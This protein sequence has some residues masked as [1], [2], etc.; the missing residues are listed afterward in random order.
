MKKI[1]IIGAGPS[2]MMAALYA[3]K[4][5]SS[6]TLLDKNKILGKKLLITGGGRCNITSN[7]PLSDFYSHIT[8]NEKFLYSS[9]NFF[10]KDELLE[11]FK[12]EGVKF[13]SEGQKIYPVSN[14]ADEILSVLEK[15]L[16]ESKVDIKLNE[17]V[18]DIIVQDFKV[19]GVKTDKNL[20]TSDCV[21]VCSGGCSYP[22][23]GSDGKLFSIL[24][25]LGIKTT[26]LYPA[27]VPIKTSMTSNLAGISLD[28]VILT[29][30]HGKKIYSTR[31]SMIFT[32]NGISGPAVLDLSSYISSYKP[33]DISLFIDFLPEISS[34]KITDVLYEKS[35]KNLY[36]RFKGYLPTELIKTILP[37]IDADKI[38]NLKKTQA[39]ELVGNLK[40]Y[41]VEVTGFGKLSEGIVT[42]GGVDLKKVNPSTL[43][44]R[45]VKGLY[46]AGEV[47][48]LDANTG[49]YNLQ[50]AFSTGALSGYSAS[51]WD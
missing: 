21:V 33:S 23:T 42:K 18:S 43:E 4:Q 45:I 38:F 14:R 1:V 2:G 48:D 17:D 46:F 49:G 22:L 50:I 36:N 28:D 3:S 9:F 47:L 8:S 20:Y 35:K 13:K 6:V 26:K 34:D 30:K 32:H 12:S 16:I 19:V 11:M 29:S 25:K 41:N 51:I 31:G 27:L 44:S 5:S 15:L 37:D 24:K 39:N 10:G 40:S 7:L